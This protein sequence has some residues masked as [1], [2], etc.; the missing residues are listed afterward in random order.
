LSK[1][2]R[3]RKKASY[4]GQPKSAECLS[5][6]IPSTIKMDAATARRLWD[7]DPAVTV[8]HFN[9]EEAIKSYYLLGSAG[10]LPRHLRKFGRNHPIVATNL[11]A[12]RVT[13]AITLFTRHGFS[14]PQFCRVVRNLEGFA[15]MK[16]KQLGDAIDCFLDIDLSRPQ[17]VEIVSQNARMLGLKVSSIKA[18]VDFFI[19][20][21]PC[22]EDVHYLLMEFGSVLLQSVRRSRQTMEILYAIDADPAECGKR[23]L[24]CP[25]LIRGRLAYLG[26]DHTLEELF[27]SNEDFLD[28]HGIDREEL[29]A[30]DPG[31]AAYQ[32]EGKR[33]RAIRIAAL[34]QK[35]AARQQVNAAQ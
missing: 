24:F 19:A 3:D 15:D 12:A 32:A 5:Y 20:E 27:L 7:V 2:H 21:L 17:A 28:R 14:L 25:A 13:D 16:E 6:V 35:I 1:K 26:K 10:L 23:Y 8:Q 29:I 11:T 31:H 33:R 4:I 9:P 18:R 22:L 30:K 34:Q